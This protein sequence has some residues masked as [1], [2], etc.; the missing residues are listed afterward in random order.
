MGGEAIGPTLVQLVCEQKE[1]RAADRSD[2]AI[3]RACKPERAGQLRS[4]NEEAAVDQDLPRCCSPSR[5]NRQ[6]R[7]AGAGIIIA[8]IECERPEM[9]RCPQEDDE[10]KRKRLEPDLSGRRG[11]SYHGWQRT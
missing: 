8:A 11:P 6:H 2:H 4:K 5:N 7:N 10:E 1:K 9:G 3:D